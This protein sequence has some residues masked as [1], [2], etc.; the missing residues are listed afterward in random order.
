[1]PS[2]ESAFSYFDATYAATLT[3]ILL[4]L[5]ALMALVQFFLLDKR[6]HYR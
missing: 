4:L 3:V 6:I 5:L 2:F 1:M